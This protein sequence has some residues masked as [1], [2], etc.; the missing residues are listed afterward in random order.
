MGTP[1]ITK[2]LFGYYRE[3]CLSPGISDESAIWATGAWQVG[4]RMLAYDYFHAITG[5]LNA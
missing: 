4:C 1:A 3:T 5:R 2:Q